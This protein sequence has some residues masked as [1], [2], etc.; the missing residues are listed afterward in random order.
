MVSAVDNSSF[1]SFTLSPNMYVLQIFTTLHSTE[2]EITKNKDP[3]ARLYIFYRF[4]NPYPG[5]GFLF[6]DF[7]FADCFLENY[8]IHRLVW[9]FGYFE[10]VTSMFC[11]MLLQILNFTNTVSSKTTFRSIFCI[12]GWC[13]VCQRN[14][15]ARPNGFK[16]LKPRKKPT[17]LS[18]QLTTSRLSTKLWYFCLP[19]L[20][21]A[22]IIYH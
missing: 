17:T 8:K 1:L 3:Q 11:L 20:H 18:G 15:Q 7:W 4:L 21:Y 14:P 5:Y 9:I 12:V 6:G 19:S 2:M 16:H 22:H 13:F 10:C